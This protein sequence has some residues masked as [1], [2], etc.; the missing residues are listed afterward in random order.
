MTFQTLKEN[1]ESENYEDFD[2]SPN[3]KKRLRSSDVRET[4]L[5]ATP[6]S[7][8]QAGDHDHHQCCSFCSKKFPWSVPELKMRVF[9]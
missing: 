1:S 7:S 2:L 3:P 6:R 9:G 4:A 8:G 5:E